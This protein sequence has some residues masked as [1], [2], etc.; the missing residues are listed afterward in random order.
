MIK[1]KGFGYL[2]ALFNGAQCT[3]AIRPF[4]VVQLYEMCLHDLRLCSTLSLTC[5]VTKPAQKKPQKPDTDFEPFHHMDQ[6][7]KNVHFQKCVQILY[8]LSA[9]QQL[10]ISRPKRRRR[11]AAIH[12]QQ[13]CADSQ[14]NAFCV[15]NFS[16]GAGQREDAG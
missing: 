12:S 14:R 3:E 16:K 5:V 15:H 8:I 11:L 9:S 13:K 7:G 10:R 6:S 4:W 1:K 2:L